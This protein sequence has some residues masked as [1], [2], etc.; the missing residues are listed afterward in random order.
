MSFT[1]Y[2]GVHG[3]ANVNAI[4]AAVE[5]SGGSV[6]V[7]ADPTIAPYEMTVRTP[8]GDNVE[9]VCY[10]FTAN[11]YAQEGRPSDEHRFQVKYGSD[12][13]NYHAIYIDPSRKKVTLFFGF[14]EE[15]DLFVAVDPAMHNPTWFSRSVEF[16]EADLREAIDEGW[17]SWERERSEARRKQDM[18]LISLQT[19]AVCAFRPEYFL[20]Y[21]AFERLATGIDPGERMLLADRIARNLSV[22][23]PSTIV[24]EPHPL[25]LELGLSAREILDV[26][27]DAFRL[28]VAVRGSVAEHHLESRLRGIKGLSQVEKIDEDGQPD[29][30]LS[31]RKRM[32]RIECKNVLR[33][34]PANGIPRVDFQKTRAT[35]GNKCSRYY[36]P[37]QFD[38]LAACVHPVTEKWE[39]MFCATSSLL[40]HKECKGKLSSNVV[41]GG[42]GWSGSLL[43]VLDGITS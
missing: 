25:E 5:R 39:Y 6:I 4:V 11:K 30:R 34:V 38:V 17:H 1:R 20:R 28:K 7:H 23:A 26:I 32:F 37:E 35:P 8:F 29:F 13:Q 33:K 43:H 36:G 3:Q 42:D 2:S 9:L 14:H 16:K 22:Q 27:G 10:A 15:L 24:L 31:Y 12:F 41:V 21:V 40:P 18:P 19:E